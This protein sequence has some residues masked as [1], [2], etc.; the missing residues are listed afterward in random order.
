MF[1]G[2]DYGKKRIG[3]ALGSKIPRPLL[4][5]ENSDQNKV[6]D[7]IINIC[8]KNEIDK[9]IIGLPEEIDQ[10]SADLREEIKQFGNRIEKLT[11][12]EIIY[13]PEAYTSVE[14][15]ERLK[16]SKQYDRMDKGRVDRESATLLLEQYINRNDEVF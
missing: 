15:E 10:N 9:I 2:I 16:Q 14:A 8:D 11:A 4:T 6:I 7:Q 13:E 1:L 3:L 5:V 12:I